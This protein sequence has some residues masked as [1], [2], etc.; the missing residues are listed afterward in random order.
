MHSQ[1]VYAGHPWLREMVHALPDGI[2]TPS[3]E[4]VIPLG[5]LFK[6]GHLMQ[7]RQRGH[8]LLDDICSDEIYTG[9]R[10]SSGQ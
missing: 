2:C 5:W 3:C 7:L 6:M 9:Q 4:T 10:T 8:R 1:M